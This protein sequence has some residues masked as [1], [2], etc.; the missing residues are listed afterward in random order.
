MQVSFLTLFYLVYL[1]C[2]GG[3][4]YVFTHFLQFPWFGF[5]AGL[6]VKGPAGHSPAKVPVLFSVSYC[7]RVKK[8]KA[9]PTT[10]E[11]NAFLRL[12]NVQPPHPEKYAGNGTQPVQG[13]KEGLYR[14]DSF[15]GRQ[16]LLQAGL[17]LLSSVPQ[18]T[19]WAV[20]SVPVW[21]KCL[22]SFLTPVATWVSN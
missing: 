1:E 3:N 8:K 11:K 14:L 12:K 5:P 16:A 15:V 19:F 6:L 4:W 2:T 7:R 22:H 9:N 10:A 17:H 13:N 18:A 20:V 21:P